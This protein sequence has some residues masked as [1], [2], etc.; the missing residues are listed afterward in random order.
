M[1]EYYMV[2]NISLMNKFQ[3]SSGKKRKERKKGKKDTTI[4]GL[5]QRKGKI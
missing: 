4:F 3:L 5:D 1:K 2:L